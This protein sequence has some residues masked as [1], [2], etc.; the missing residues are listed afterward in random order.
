MAAAPDVLLLDEPFGALD[1]VTR[2]KLQ[3][4]FRRIREELGPTVLFVTHDMT[5]ALLLGDR[6][7]VMAEG[8]LL[9]VATPQELLN[10]PAHPRVSELLEAPKRQRELLSRWFE[11]EATEPR[12]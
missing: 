9:Q 5:E 11:F 10:H 8:A 3:E 2:E 12:G 4:S 6:I 1:P 7:A